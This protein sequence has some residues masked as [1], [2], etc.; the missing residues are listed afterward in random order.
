MI[1]NIHK[2]YLLKKFT[3]KIFLISSIFF[4]LVLIINLIEEANFLKNTEAHFFTP[5]FLTILNTP[6]I[7]YEMLPFIFILST[8]F[9]FID[10]F[11]KKEIDTLR[12]FGL[13]N[14]DILKFLSITSIIF[15]LLIVVIFY[16]F[17]AVLKNEYLK[18]KNNYA[19]DNKYLAVIT[20]NGLW[21]K[22]TTNK[23]IIIINADRIENDYLINTSL[24]QFDKNYLLKRNII[25]EK[26]N[27]KNYDWILENVTVT[28][29]DNSTLRYEKMLFKSSFNSE[30]IINLFSDLSA[31]TYFELQD[32]KLNY[33]SIGYSTDEINV[34]NHKI[35]SLPFLLMLM[36][37][38]SMIIMINNKFQKNLLFNILIGIFFSV[39]V[40]YLSHFSNLL[41]ENGKLPIILSVWFP[42][43]IILIVSLMGIV[44]LNEK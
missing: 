37:I 41:G 4:F 13:N 14:F 36:T 26:A 8:Q 38:I 3:K 44:K 21:L 1:I 29:L 39:T 10:I 20:K 31:L 24:S 42:V 40:Y 35:Y 5:I 27:I 12:Q 16:N 18:I 43:L 2:S 15:G 32:L 28:E 7:L 6:T 17:S 11:E 25:A 23:E 19:D 34:Q 22:D 9:F 33:E 30:K